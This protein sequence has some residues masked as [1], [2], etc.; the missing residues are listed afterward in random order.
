MDAPPAVLKEAQNLLARHLLQVADNNRF[1]TQQKY[2]EQGASA[3]HLLA[4]IIRSQRASAHIAK[5]ESAEGVEVLEGADILRVL[6]SYYETL[7][8]SKFS[9]PKHNRAWKTLFYVRR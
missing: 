7:Y 6:S 2:F 4:T 3:G 9:Q 8:A 5:L 1:F